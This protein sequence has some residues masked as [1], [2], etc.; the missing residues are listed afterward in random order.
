MDTKTKKKGQADTAPDAEKIE[1]KNKAKN[2]AE[3]KDSKQEDKKKKGV[4]ATTGKVFSFFVP[5]RGFVGLGSEMKS[6][7]KGSESIFK[8]FGALY[9]LLKIGLAF[10]FK[11]KKKEQLREELF[12]VAKIDTQNKND[13]YIR[14]P[15][16]VDDPASKTRNQLISIHAK[17]RGV[18]PKEEYV[19]LKY[20]H[21]RNKKLAKSFGILFLVVLGVN[22]VSSSMMPSTMFNLVAQLIMYGITFSYFAMFRYLSFKNRNFLMPITFK[23]Y[24]SYVLKVDI[25]DLLAGKPFS[26]PLDATKEGAVSRKKYFG[27]RK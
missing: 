13:G 23:Q 24:M 16:I 26:Q 7:F 6:A 9:R 17:D 22:I 5:T 11:R 18:H 27:G 1:D 3:N 4:I 25:M 21:D 2:D 12:A 19:F 8:T 20:V 14:Y 10:V 15:D